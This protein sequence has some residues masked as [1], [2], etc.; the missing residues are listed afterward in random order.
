M[1]SFHVAEDL[2]LGYDMII[3]LDILNTL[4]IVIDYTRKTLSW[5]EVK[6]NIRKM[7]DFKVE[8]LC[9][10]V[11]KSIEPKST[12]SICKHEI[13][14]LDAQYDTENLTELANDFFFIFI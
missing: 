11:A 7:D 6:I 8:D 9:A 4:V 5:D 12:K 3:R 2:H 10:L 13:N 14:I 1:L